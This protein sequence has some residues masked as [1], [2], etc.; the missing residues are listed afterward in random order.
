MSVNL[1]DIWC[2]N[3]RLLGMRTVDSRQRSEQECLQQ[4]HSAQE[5][6][7]MSD[8]DFRCASS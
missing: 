7:K 4:L 5:N 8:A 6:S 3:R 2:E 1:P